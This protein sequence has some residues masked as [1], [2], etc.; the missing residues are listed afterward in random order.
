MNVLILIEIISDQNRAIKTHQFLWLEQ[1][2]KT[3]NQESAHHRNVGCVYW[4][5]PTT[6]LAGMFIAKGPPPQWWMCLL[7]KAHH[8][9][10]GVFIGKGP[11][12]NGGCVYWQKPTTSM[13][14]CLLAKTHHLING[15]CVYWQRPITSMVGVFIAKGPPATTQNNNFNLKLL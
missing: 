3:I 10:G 6:S 9:N 13:V 14:V 15:G 2:Y 11:H 8:L 5:R 4:Q 7:P 1:V 12:L